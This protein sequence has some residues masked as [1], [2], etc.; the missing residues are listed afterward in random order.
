[1]SDQEQE[2]FVAMGGADGTVQRFL[3]RV[4][5][6]LRGPKLLRF[7]VDPRVWMQ[8]MHETNYGTVPG[9]RFGDHFELCTPHGYVPVLVEE[10]E[11]CT[12]RAV[13]HDR[14]ASLDFASVL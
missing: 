10:H 5:V 14:M 13:M 3:L 6:F 4:A 1:M 8:L 9:T 7:T 12:G 2:M 11:P